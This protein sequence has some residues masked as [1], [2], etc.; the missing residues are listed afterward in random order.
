MYVCIC[1][2][3]R[4]ADVAEAVQC[5]AHCADSVA[6]A[7][8]ASTGCGTCRETLCARVAAHRATPARIEA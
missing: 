4:D 8:G 3:V 7:T 2:A 5:G 1:F 6:E